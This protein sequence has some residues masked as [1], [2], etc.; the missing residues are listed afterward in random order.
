LIKGS[1]ALW[2]IAANYTTADAPTLARGGILADDM[3]LG[4]TLQL[5]SLILEGTPGTTLIM[6]PVS[7]MSNWS[8]QMERVS[9]PFSFCYSELSQFTDFEVL[10]HIKKDKLLKVLTIMAPAEAK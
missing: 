8:Q 3:G 7:V 5:I 4:K 1:T 9:N 6:A 2:A 10:L